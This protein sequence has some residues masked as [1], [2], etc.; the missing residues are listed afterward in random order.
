MQ[1][2]YSD[3]LTSYN[4]WLEEVIY[5]EYNLNEGWKFYDKEKAPEAK[6]N[7]NN[8]RDLISKNSGTTLMSCDNFSRSTGFMCKRKDIM[9]IKSYRD[10]ACGC[11]L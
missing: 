3:S 1:S 2:T 4:K 10:S 8:T 9:N 6:D 5:V 7:T 11:P